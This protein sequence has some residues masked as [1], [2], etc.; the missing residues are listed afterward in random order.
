MAHS[1]NLH[2]GW[3]TGVHVHTTGLRV[4]GSKLWIANGWFGGR[5]LAV[6]CNDNPLRGLWIQHHRA[7]GI[8]SVAM[9]HARQQKIR[10]P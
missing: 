9:L 2:P 1:T 6:W 8:S 10:A 7:Y 3:W 4:H 5:V